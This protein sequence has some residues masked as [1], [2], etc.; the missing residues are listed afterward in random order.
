MGKFNTSMKSV[1]LKTALHLELP[2]LVRNVDGPIDFIRPIIFSRIKG[3][4]K[5]EEERK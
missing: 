5:S 3:R 2:E 1:M 4:L